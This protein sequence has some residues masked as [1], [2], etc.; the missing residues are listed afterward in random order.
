M[1]GISWHPQLPGGFRPPAFDELALVRL[2][3]HDFAG[4]P[5]WGEL[6]VASQIAQVVIDVFRQV[7]AA[8]FPIE[9]MQ[10]IDHYDADDERSMAANNSSAFN[11]RVIAGTT[12]PSKH[13]SGLAIDINPVQNPYVV[14]DAV[15]PEAGRAY[16]DRSQH[17][18]GMLHPDDAVVR[19]FIDAGF[20]WGGS[21]DSPKDYHHFEW[22]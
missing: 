21:W 12:Q 14:G 3:H 8:K 6:I 7:Y 22:A 20:V 10:R 17:R 15:H 19:A 1:R 4:Q 2:L 16:L 13:A 5:K 9:R 18:P 11:C